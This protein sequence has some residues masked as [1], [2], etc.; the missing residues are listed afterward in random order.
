MPQLALG[1]LHLGPPGSPPSLAK[2]RLLAGALAGVCTLLSSALFHA[3]ASSSPAVGQA[4]TVILSLVEAIERGIPLDARVRD[5]LGD[6]AAAALN[7]SRAQGATGWQLTVNPRV[8]LKGY[9]NEPYAGSQNLELNTSLLRPT[10][11]GG[12]L[13]LT[14]NLNQSLSDNLTVT[15]VARY[16]Q[17]IFPLVLPAGVQATEWERRLTLEQRRLAVKQEQD[18]AALRIA[19]TYFNLSRAEAGLHSAQVAVQRAKENVTRA[20]ALAALQ[21]G[22]PLALE[23]AR[24]AA[25]QAQLDLNV[26]QQ[27]YAEAQEAL[28][29][30][31]GLPPGTVVEP[32]PFRVSPWGVSLA[33]ATNVALANRA[34]LR[35]LA[36]T[37]EQAELNA[38]RA[39]ADLAPQLSSSGGVGT[40]VKLRENQ[41]AH[42][43]GWEVYVNLTLPWFDGVPRR[44]AA[45]LAEATLNRARQDEERL[46]RQIVAEVRSRW[47]E[48][49][50]AKERLRLAEQR[51]ALAEAQLALTREQVRIGA[52]AESVAERD[53]DNVRASQ[54]AEANARFDYVL[55][56]ARLQVAMGESP[57]ILF[58]TQ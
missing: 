19:A 17:P 44:E 56:V 48:V 45:E 40:G 50:Q 5:V 52:Q 23:Q 13:T 4:P 6:Q 29:S 57:T 35:S 15:W 16:S 14:T 3:G 36:L 30:S 27:K 39:R 31:V 28:A 18:Q 25:E 1:R 41:K 22:K 21:Q 47:V 10:P 37:I 20:E 2:R 7:L 12:Q 54:V 8:S 55:A 9:L 43:I 49:E 34:E 42:E 11:L 51:L 32:T 38:R 53:E 33:E 58:E 46:H 26:A 24:L